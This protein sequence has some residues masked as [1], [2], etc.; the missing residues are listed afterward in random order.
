MTNA[1]R[2]TLLE[3]YIHLLETDTLNHLMNLPSMSQI[4]EQQYRIER[5][6]MEVFQGLVRT[7]RDEINL[8]R[9]LDPDAL[10]QAE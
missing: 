7:F 6:R 4:Y 3:S 2:I 10:Y 8:L 9:N 1:E 5:N